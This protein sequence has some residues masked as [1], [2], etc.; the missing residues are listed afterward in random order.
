[1]FQKSEGN[2]SKSF[3]ILLLLLCSGCGK[4]DESNA[5]QNSKHDE[6]YDLNE[7]TEVI[8]HLIKENELQKI[9]E[10]HD[11]EQLKTLLKNFSPSEMAVEAEALNYRGIA[12]LIFYH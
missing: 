12:A 7:S 11:P 6:V 1:M 2:M 9:M 8:M 4:S 5:L 10:D 3:F